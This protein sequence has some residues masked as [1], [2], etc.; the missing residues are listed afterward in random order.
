MKTAPL[1]LL[2]EE[3]AV[4]RDRVY[5]NHAGTGPL[6]A[7][8]VA[9]I[10]DWTARCASEGEV[11]WPEAEALV[12]KARTSAAALLRV[13]AE[14]VAFTKNATS[15]AL[16]AMGS[17]PWRAGDNVILQGSAFPVN[18]AVLRNVLPDVER[19]HARTA[20]EIAALVDARTRAIAVDWVHFATGERIDLQPLARLCRERNIYFLVDVAQ[21]LGLVDFD[22]GSLGADFVYGCGNKWL[23]GLQGTGLLHIRA[24]TL[25]GLRPFNLGW[26]SSARPDF[27]DMHAVYPLKPDARRHEEGTKNYTGIVALGASLSLLQDAGPAVIEARSR[28]LTGLLRKKLAEL[29]FDV[30]TPAEPERSAGILSVRK[31]GVDHAA[32]YAVLRNERCIV[33]LREGA[34]R[35]SPHF[36]N[37][38]AEALRLVDVLAAATNLR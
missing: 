9:A 38:E 30:L 21:G 14:E 29:G 24:A 6:P 33:S 22:F 20:E 17:V 15:G 11:P 16:I 37:T 19:R 8:T 23:L 31:P 28:S 4:A 26:L 13:Q 34:L 25:R 12:E 10:H 1:D 7:R 32:M 5:F 35:I 2:R 36:Y 3:F 18:E 27:T